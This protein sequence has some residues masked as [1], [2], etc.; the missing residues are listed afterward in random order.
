MDKEAFVNCF[1]ARKAEVERK[2]PNAFDFLSNG[3]DFLVL[4]AA[5]FF[6]YYYA[7][8]PKVDKLLGKDGKEVFD[9]GQWTKDIG[10][11]LWKFPASITEK[12]TSKLGKS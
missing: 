9:Y 6:L 4:M 3:W 5:I 10:T 2:Y 1:N 12:I 8:N 7:I 11:Q